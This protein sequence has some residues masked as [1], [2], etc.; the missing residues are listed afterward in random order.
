[1]SNIRDISRWVTEL[2]FTDLPSPVV[3]KAKEVSLNSWGVQLAASTLDWSKSSY[4]YGRSQGGTPESTVINYGFRTSAANAA[5]ING[6]FA[7]GFEMDDNHGRTGIKGGCV[8]VPTALAVGERQL[9]DGK[10]F[11]TALVAGYEVMTRAGLAGYKGLHDGGHHPT[12]HLGA[13]GAA[14]ITSKLLG[15]DVDATAH[16]L[17]IAASHMVGLSFSGGDSKSDRGYLKRTYGG[18]AAFGGIRAALLAREGM[19]GSEALLE[20]GAGFCRAF[21]VDETDARMFTAGLGDAWEILRA[22]YKIYAQDGHIQPMTEALERI[23]KAHSFTASDV[24][25]VRVGTNRV[26]NDLIVGQIREPRDLTDAQYSANFSVAL[27][28]VRGGAGFQEYTEDNILT[29]PEIIDL[30]RRVTLEIDPEIEAEFQRTHP[31]GARV[32]VRL[33]SGE[34]YTELVENLRAMTPEDI[35]DKFRRLS[36]VVLDAQRGEALLRRVRSLEEVR[37][38]SAL[39]PLFLN[40]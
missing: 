16:A 4:R 2:K 17:S 8:T 27:Y 22:H 20:P 32:T 38:V 5:F 18:T 12:G 13:L 34:E 40:Q 7:H 23:R 10:A 29:D 11:I 6:C 28:L 19:T 30:S 25:S 9:S 3:E 1:M 15:F 14:T 37:D 21:G 24:D 31:R 26:A 39:L 33:R 35:D 36:S